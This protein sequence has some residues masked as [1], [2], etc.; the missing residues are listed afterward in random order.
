MVEVHSITNG[1]ANLSH[2]GIIGYASSSCLRKKEN[3]E[4]DNDCDLM[5]SRCY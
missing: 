5:E 1:W 2:N 3:V 4:I